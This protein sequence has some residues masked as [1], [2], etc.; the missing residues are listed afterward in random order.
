MASERDGDSRDPQPLGERVD[1]LSEER[2]RLFEELG[3][4]SAGRDHD[5]QPPEDSAAG[6][7]GRH[8]RDGAGNPGPQNPWDFW[9]QAAGQAGPQQQNPWSQFWQQAA[10]QAGPQQQNPWS[11]FWQQAAGQAGPQQQNPWSQFWQQAAGQ[12]GPQQ[13]NPWGQAA[14]PFAGPGQPPFAAPLPPNPWQLWQQ[15]FAALAQPGPVFWQ[16]FSTAPGQ[17]NLWA[18]LW[19]CPD[20]GRPNTG[21]EPD[22]PGA[23]PGSPLVAMK[24]SGSRPP[25]FCVHALLGS[26]FPYHKLALHMP[27]DQPFYGLRAR[28]LD[29]RERPR[30]RIEE[31]AA[32]YIPAIR[33]VQPTGPY[34][35]GGYSL[36]GWVAFEMA[37]Q[38]HRDGERVRVLANFGAG[39]PPAVG[40]PGLVEQ[41]DFFIQYMEDCT[42]LAFNANQPEEAR[43]AIDFDQAIRQALNLTPLQ[44][45]TLANSLAQLRYVPGPYA[46][47]LDLFVTEEQQRTS[48][49]E[50]TMGWKILCLDGVAVHAITGNHLNMFEE[51]H[52]QSL[53]EQLRAC[54]EKGT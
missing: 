26:A 12:A 17:P 20:A 4:R 19:Q 43:A 14:G 27:E 39:V 16:S 45:V 32:A 44:R 51:P 10:G 47:G 21:P 46:A 5:D 33:S 23:P 35:L 13:Q 52:V 11:Q 9:Q 1:G 25:F 36:G 28:G 24:P 7:A 48:Q 40:N 18:E 15:L 49:T 37:R 30:E 54:L 22:S 29:G 53:A 41:M 8:E 6:G 2:R 38:L 50:P 34:H 31:M 42:R 3:N